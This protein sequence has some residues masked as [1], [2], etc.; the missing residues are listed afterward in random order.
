MM[1]ESNV[2]KCVL[3]P[4]LSKT[5]LMMQDAFLFPNKKGPQ[6]PQCGR[7]YFRETKLQTHKYLYVCN[8]II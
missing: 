3:Y 2:F 7:I 8:V 4:F 5:H 1:C 6:H